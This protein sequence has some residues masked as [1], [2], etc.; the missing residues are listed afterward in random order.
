MKGSTARQ[1]EYVYSKS[2]NEKLIGSQQVNKCE[3]DDKPQV[4]L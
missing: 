2:K 4:D 3:N 1:A